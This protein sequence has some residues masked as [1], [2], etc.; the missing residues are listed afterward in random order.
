MGLAFQFMANIRLHE[1]EMKGGV[2][3]KNNAVVAIPRDT[4]REL[5]NQSSRLPHSEVAVSDV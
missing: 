2:Q 4:S 3:A 5:T 1:L